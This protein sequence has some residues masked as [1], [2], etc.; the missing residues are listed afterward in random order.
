MSAEDDRTNGRKTLLPEFLPAP[1]AGGGLAPRE[2]VAE[3]A[4][5]LLERFRGIGTTAGAAVLSLQCGTGYGVVDPLPPPPM[6][7][8]TSTD[9]FAG[10]QAIAMVQSGT[11]APLP[12]V[13]SLYSSGYPPNNFVG[14][15]ID[16]VRITRGTL[17]AIDDQTNVNS[18]TRLMI[19]IA[20]TSQPPAEILVDVDLGCGSAALTKHYRILQQDPQ[21]PNQSLIVTEDTTADAGTD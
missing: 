6:Q 3:R 18:Q 1:Q 12:I 14:Y 16:A 21:I 9:P 20:P 15:R 19:T 10:L 7:C 13:L 2:R 5:L 4:R 8:T 11:T 17:V